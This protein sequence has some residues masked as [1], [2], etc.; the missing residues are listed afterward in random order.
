MNAEE[1]EQHDYPKYRVPTLEGVPGKK[2][3]V[4]G[5]RLFPLRNGVNKK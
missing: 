5:C 2:L 4:L 1:L 3:V